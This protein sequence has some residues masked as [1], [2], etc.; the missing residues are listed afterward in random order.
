MKDSKSQATEFYGTTDAAQAVPC[1]E[2][3]LRGYEKRGIISP[4]RTIS[5]RRVFTTKD[6]QAVRKYRSR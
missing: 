6:I 4:A 5:G 1:S 3:A 2:S